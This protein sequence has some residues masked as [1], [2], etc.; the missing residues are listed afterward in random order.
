MGTRLNWRSFI[1]ECLELI[2]KEPIIYLFFLHWL[3]QNSLK[4]Q[5][6]QIKSDQSGLF[7]TNLII[8]V[9]LSRIIKGKTWLVGRLFKSNLD[10]TRF[11]WGLF[12]TPSEKTETNY[13][14]IKVDPTS[15]KLFKT[16]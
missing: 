2:Y 14:S 10:D 16:I 11:S 3:A 13:D 4:L 5:L 6:I 1:K 7:G 8:S 12:E 9:K 15:L